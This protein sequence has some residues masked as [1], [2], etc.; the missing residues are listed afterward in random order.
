MIFKYVIYKITFPNGK[1]YIG[2]DVGSIGHT[3]SYFGSWDSSLIEQDFTKAQLADFTLRKEILLE[4]EDKQLI[5]RK[6]AE[7]IRLYKS[8]EAAIGYN[9]TCRVRIKK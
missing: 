4:S 9:Q 2:K 5:N 8:N 6:E 3:M 7:F 1:I